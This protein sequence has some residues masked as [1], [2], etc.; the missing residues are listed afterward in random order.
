M[1]SRLMAL[2][3]ELI[4][5]LNMDSY[6]K[7]PADIDATIQYFPRPL[8][9]LITDREKRFNVEVLHRRFG[10][11]VM[12]IRKL[13]YRASHCPFPD[14]RYAYIAPTYRQAE[15]IAWTYLSNAVRLICKEGGLK[16]KDW[17]NKS[18]LEVS[19]PTI[20][21][22]AARIKLY[23]VDDPK[24]RMR[25]T[26]LD[27]VVF[28]EF[29]WIPWSV[30]TD[31][32][33]PM[34]TDENRSGVDFTGQRNQ[35]ADFIFTP[36]GRNHAYT[37]FKKALAWS[38]NRP[39]VEVDPDTGQAEEIRRDDWFAAIYNVE[40]TGVL[41][42]QEL[43]AA[44]LDMGRVKYEQE[45]MCSF[46]AAVTG[47]IY[48]VEIEDARAQGRVRSVP[49][50]KRLPVHT[51]WDLGM[52]DATAIWMFQETQGEIRFI[53]YY[54]ASGMALDHYVDVLAERRYR[55]GYMLFPHDVEV[56]ELATGKS[57]RAILQNMGM[58]NLR[59]VPRHNVQDGIAAV[60]AMFPRCVFDQEK[61]VDGLDR[62][63]M[64]RREWDER[65]AVMRPK[66]VHDWASHGAD[67]FRTAVMGR[68]DLS[69]EQGQHNQAVTTEY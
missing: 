9:A 53:D 35:W 69:P 44:R 25:G 52:D 64:Y 10:K 61:C 34:L 26:Y 6:A 5:E 45:Y 56:R 41:S 40:Q 27:G 39:V 14:G 67:A 32:V 12:K 49:W 65:L 3:N 28:D 33:R 60:Q 42:K 7:P 55:Y 54:E 29:A 2:T 66:P 46:D 47:A 13:I 17:I 68:R 30:W 1:A 20:E 19:I 16:E 38:E 23:G 4:R 21:G 36:F 8:Q 43:Q 59:T 31:Q 58:R 51:A 18:N 22:S 48:A 50:D 63:A 11:T 57:R 37:M 24:Q 15:D 62:L